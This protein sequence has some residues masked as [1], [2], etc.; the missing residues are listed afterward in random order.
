MRIPR[1]LLLMSVL[2]LPLAVAAQS[3]SQETT[4]A[5]VFVVNY[6]SDNTFLGWGTGFFVDEGIVVTNRHVIEAGDW[7]RVYATNANGAVDMACSKKITKSDVKINLDDDVAYMRV[8]LDCAHGSMLFADDPRQDDPVWI[9]GYPYRGSVSA[10]TVLAVSTGSV[11]GKTTDGWLR[12]DAYL[13]LGNSG[14]PVVNDTGVI[15]V[16]VAKSVDDNGGFI[17]GYFIPASVIEQGLLYANDSRFGYTP[18]SRSSVSRSSASSARSVSSSSSSSSSRMSSHSSSRSS[19]RSS[20][21]NPFYDVSSTREGYRAILSLYERGVIRGYADGTYRPDAG[22]NRA[23]FLKILVA[24]FHPEELRG[25]T[26]C[27]VDVSSQWFA[28]YVCAAKR[29]GWISGYPD[30]TFRPAQLVNRAE[31]MKIVIGT[32][33]G[34]VPAAQ[35]LPSDVRSGTWFETYVARGVTLDIVDPTERFRPESNLTRE[36][37]ALWI[38]GA[39]MAILH[40]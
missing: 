14:G 38:D 34:S 36:D 39:E 7:Y 8:F 11:I 13:D 3:L 6:D 29:M 15:G 40:S 31:A 1:A 23:E 21:R 4:T 33:G 12:T 37:A 26:D 10:S 28:P 24:G 5:V 17:A 9:L 16:A 32:F 18:Q 20:V 19:S 22:I 35:Q 25:D 30:G 2:L 27:F